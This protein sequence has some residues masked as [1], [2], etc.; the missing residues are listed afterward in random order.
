MRKKSIGTRELRRIAS[1]LDRFKPIPSSNV[2]ELN[3]DSKEPYEKNCPAQSDRKEVWF[4]SGDT[5]ACGFSGIKADSELGCGYCM[6]SKMYRRG[7]EK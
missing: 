7:M 1:A 6:L 3:V 2:E 4:P 5:Y